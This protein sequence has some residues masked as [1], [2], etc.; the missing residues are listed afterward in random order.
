MIKKKPK[1]VV[2]S[3]LRNKKK[4]LNT[5]MK[6]L[7]SGLS[8]FKCPPSPRVLCRNYYDTKATN[9]LL[10]PY[11]ITGF[12]DGESCFILNVNKSPDSSTGYRVKAT[13]QISLSSKDRALLEEIQ[14]YF[15]GIGYMYKCPVGML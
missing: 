4:I 12:A 6:N 14:I 13:F 15:G 8:P 5:S 1:Y 9:H 11:F 3:V 2:R 7:R 10:H